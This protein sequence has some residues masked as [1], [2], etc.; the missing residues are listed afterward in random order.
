MLTRR[1]SF[2]EMVTRT[3]QDQR[4]TMNYSIDEEAE[5]EDDVVAD[6]T[7]E[8]PAVNLSEKLK[9]K[10]S[11]E[12]EHS[13]IV[14]L[15]G[16]PLRNWTL[17]SKIAILWKPKGSNKIFGEGYHFRGGLGAFSYPAG[18]GIFWLLRCRK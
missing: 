9:G 3:E 6:F 17:G 8:W 4:P 14:T 16:R 10:I 12:W 5:E 18:V 2:L 13:V 1:P 15:L 7:R 11:T